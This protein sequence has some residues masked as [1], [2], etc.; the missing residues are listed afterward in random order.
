MVMNLLCN[1][2]T[3][4]GRLSRLQ[5]VADNFPAD[6]YILQGPILAVLASDSKQGVSQYMISVFDKL[7]F[8]NPGC[9][10]YG[11]SLRL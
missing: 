4:L 5:I 3:G 11:S 7:Y 2:L 10:E 8:W 6:N 1:V 9:Y